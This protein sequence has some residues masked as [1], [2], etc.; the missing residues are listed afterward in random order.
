MTSILLAMNLAFTLFRMEPAEALQGA[1][2]NAAKALGLEA[3]CGTIEEGKA[4]DLA[5]WDISHPS[6][7][8]YWM[9]SLPLYGRCFAGVLHPA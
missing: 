1:T 6:E 9:G 8:S 5:I 3:L 2:S 4:R 7:L